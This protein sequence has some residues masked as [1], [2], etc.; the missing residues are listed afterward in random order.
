MTHTP[1]RLSRWSLPLA[2]GGAVAVI[3]APLGYRV[4]AVPLVVALL[5]PVVGV[6]LSI[7]VLV[8]AVTTLVRGRAA[9]EKRVSVMGAAAIAAV[10]G[11][12]PLFIVLSA[13]GLPAIHDV[14]TDLDDPP[15]FE[16]V[17]PLRAD[18]PNSLEHGGQTVADAQREAYPELVT[19]VLGHPSD[20]VVD[21]AHDVAQ[22]LGWEIV[23]V[24]REAGR[25][26]A[27]AT[28]LWF[29]FK[30]DVVVRVRPG[31]TGVRVDVRSVSRVGGG[32]LGANAARVQAFLE[33]L[34]ARAANQE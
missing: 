6:L 21:W 16:A 2:I 32:D 33:R 24:D 9:P 5:G 12:T 17:V 7:V 31:Q 34:E 23:A 25:V 3:G 30:D 28:T 22:E 14:T 19:L 13:T 8:V 15:R 18:A 27:T 20:Q 26:E 29:G 4:G 11:F 10:C 1:G